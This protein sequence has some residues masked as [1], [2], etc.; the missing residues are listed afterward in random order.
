M[1]PK[2]FENVFVGFWFSKSISLLKEGA[3]LTTVNCH[4]SRMDNEWIAYCLSQQWFATLYSDVLS[5][6]PPNQ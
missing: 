4:I 5:I 6:I 1:K 3:T 2:Y